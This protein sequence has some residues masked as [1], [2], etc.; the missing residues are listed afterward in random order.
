[1]YLVLKRYLYTR[2]VPAVIDN[3]IIVYLNTV[4]FAQFVK[5]F[6]GWLLILLI[7]LIFQLTSVINNMILYLK[8]ARNPKTRKSVARNQALI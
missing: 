3:M 8:T 7:L 4:F 5:K 1:M 6:R 2:F